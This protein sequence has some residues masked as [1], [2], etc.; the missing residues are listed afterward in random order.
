MYIE[1]NPGKREESQSQQNNT[2]QH[3]DQPAMT[4][5]IRYAL[6]HEGDKG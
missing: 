6:G 5:D 4:N 3:G 2:G 1:K